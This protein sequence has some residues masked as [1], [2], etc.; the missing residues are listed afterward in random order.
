[1]SSNYGLLFFGWSAKDSPSHIF[2][3][4]SDFMSLSMV[5]DEFSSLSLAKGIRTDSQGEPLKF[6]LA[7]FEPVTTD[8][9]AK[10]QKH[11]ASEAY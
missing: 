6:S 2:E 5:N 10:C 4:F 1:M 3:Q 9:R 11:L 7:G 8:V